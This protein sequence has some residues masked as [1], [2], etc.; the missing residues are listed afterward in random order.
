MKKPQENEFQ[1]IKLTKYKVGIKVDF[2]IEDDPNTYQVTK[3]DPPHPDL[4][5]VLSDFDEILYETSG[6]KKEKE[7]LRMNLPG[8]AL[9]KLDSVKKWYNEY[10]K[11]Q[12]QMIDVTSV[13]FSAEKEERKGV[14]IKGSKEAKN[15]Y[16][17]TIESPKVIFIESDFEC[18]SKAEELYNQLAQE[19]YK[20]IYEDKGLQ[21]TAKFE[22]EPEYEDE[23]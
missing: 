15:G 13:E 5:K 4:T 21:L 11:G 12:I 2:T 16:V 20:M 23:E 17:H 10:D 1:L 18:E 3:T 19:C 6:Y 7:L 8:D 9:K 14:K 22:S